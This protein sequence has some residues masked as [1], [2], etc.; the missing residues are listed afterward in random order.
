MLVASAPVALPI[1]TAN[2]PTEAVATEVAHK[3]PVTE[4]PKTAESPNSRTSTDSNEQQRVNQESPKEANQNQ[5]KEE[6][7]ND[8]QESNQQ[9]RQEQQQQN[10]EKQEI[11]GLRSRDR[12]V[13]AHEAA[14]AAV[15]GAFAGSPQLTFK[16]GPDGQRYAVAGEVAI[17][18]SKAATPEATLTKMG[19]IQR[20]ALA[21]ADPST[22]DRIVAAKAGRLADEAK[23]EIRQVAVEEVQAAQEERKAQA[24][25][26]EDKIDFQEDQKD[27]ERSFFNPLAVRRASLLLNQKIINS[28]ALDDPESEPLL[29]RTA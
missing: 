1:N 28:G 27:E 22:Q 23:V 20:A 21:P 4:P 10:Q 25:D 13:R 17:D 24:I 3:T 15:G 8:K 18:I 12:E 26:D 6:S 2:P 5:S 9:E 19:Q 29:S 11:E 16:T 7:A 14:H